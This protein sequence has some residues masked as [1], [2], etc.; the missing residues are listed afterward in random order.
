MAIELPSDVGKKLLEVSK[1]LDMEEE[2]IVN[3]DV[4]LYLD[5]AQKYVDLKK[6][7][8]VWDELSDEAFNNFER[9]NCNDFRFGI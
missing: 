3:R 8:K 7:L 5:N 6:E 4:S 2:E 9:G 1:L